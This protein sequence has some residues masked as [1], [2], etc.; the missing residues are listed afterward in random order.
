MCLNP[1]ATR[2]ALACVCLVAVAL[3]SG[4]RASPRAQG[5][6][7]DR[8]RGSWTG[9]LTYR[10]YSSNKSVSI[11]INMHVDV[12]GAPEPGQPPRVGGPARALSF[13]RRYPDEPHANSAETVELSRDGRRFG[14]ETVTARVEPA[15][16]MVVIETRE[17]GSDNDRPALL[18][19]T[20]TLGPDVFIA[21]KDIWNEQA[22]VFEN[23]NV[24]R[25]TREGVSIPPVP[26]GEP[27][28][29]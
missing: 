6:D 22:Q 20:Y 4:C 7:F 28:A 29:R 26:P 25:F 27:A 11:P 19:H 15:P 9:T 8:L 17:W 14:D 21:S 24:S 18:R 23:R 13:L 1:I 16:G 2:H 5:S 3:V 12:A 10:D